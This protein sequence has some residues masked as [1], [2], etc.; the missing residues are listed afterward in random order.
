MDDESKPEATTYLHHLET[1]ARLTQRR[2]GIIRLAWEN[3][4]TI[5]QIVAASGLNMAYVYRIIGNVRAKTRAR[6]AQVDVESL[7]RPG[8][9]R[10]TI[11]RGKVAHVYVEAAQSALCAFAPHVED[12]WNAHAPE[13]GAPTCKLCDRILRIRAV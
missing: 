3:G 1:W 11:G 5:H 8:E 7:L 4:A 6:E 10:R 12:G 2:D 13:D 9:A